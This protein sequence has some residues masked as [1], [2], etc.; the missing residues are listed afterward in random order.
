MDRD[1]R[2]GRAAG[3]AGPLARRALRRPRRAETKT[4]GASSCARRVLS[5]ALRSSVRCRALAELIPLAGRRPA[6]SSCLSSSDRWSHASDLRQ[7]PRAD[8]PGY[9]VHA[10]KRPAP[11]L[12][13]VGPR[14]HDTVTDCGLLQVAAHPVG[15][16]HGGNHAQLLRRRRPKVQVRGP[17]CECA[18]PSGVTPT[19]S[20]RLDTVRRSPSWPASPSVTCSR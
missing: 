4:I 14:Q 9:P 5:R 7:E 2:L 10:L 11:D 6:R 13:E 15:L 8:L 20:N 3:R 17:A 16:N 12:V 1:H 19:N 18:W